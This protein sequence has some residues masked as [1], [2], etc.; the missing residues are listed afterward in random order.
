MKRII[1]L[2]LILQLMTGSVLAQAEPNRYEVE[3]LTNPNAGKKDTREV[4]AVLIFEKD[5]IKIQ[6][7]RSRTT[8]SADHPADEASAPLLKPGGELNPATPPLKGGE[9]K[10]F[11]YSDIRSVEHSYSR[12][13]PFQLSKGTAIALSLLSGMPLFLMAR[14]KDKHWLMV[15]T[16]EDYAVLKI[17]NDNY[18]LIRMEFIVKKIDIVDIDENR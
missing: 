11:K 18:R 15:S 10:K 13:H 2:T 7:R 8:P 4:N 5:G 1:V 12:K 14:Q 3:I 6:S 16:D 9:F 17:E